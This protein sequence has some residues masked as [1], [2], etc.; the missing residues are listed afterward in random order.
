M[1]HLLDVRVTC[2]GE[3]GLINYF[4]IR[5]EILLLI[6]GYYNI[7]I[8]PCS[9]TALLEC[10]RDQVQL[11][12]LAIIKSIIMRT[13]IGDHHR[14]TIDVFSHTVAQKLRN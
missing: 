1:R 8:N 11:K 2:Q 10:G 3:Q 14:T 6:C 5:F 9:Y 12:Y 13:T 7:I 4:L